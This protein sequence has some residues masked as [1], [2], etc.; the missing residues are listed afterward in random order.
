MAVYAHD[1]E[2]D[3]WD[4]ELSDDDESSLFSAL[5]KQV[6]ALPPL[7][8][9][10]AGPAPAHDEAPRGGDSAANAVVAPGTGSTQQHSAMA[11]NTSS[12]S[13][14][15]VASG[16]T[17]QRRLK[18]TKGDQISWK[19]RET[20]SHRVDFS[21]FFVRVGMGPGD[22]IEVKPSSRCDGDTGTYVA[23]GS[24]ELV[25]MF[26]NQFSW[27][28][29]KLVEFEVTRLKPEGSDSGSPSGA[30]EHAGL[31][32]SAKSIS[33][34]PST[35]AEEEARVE[36]RGAASEPQKTLPGGDKEDENALAASTEREESQA[37]RAKRLWEAEAEEARAR[38]R[39]QDGE[40]ED[41]ASNQGTEEDEVEASD[42]EEND[43]ADQETDRDED[44]AAANEDKK[45]S[46]VQIGEE[47]VRD[48]TWALGLIEKGKK[49]EAA[50]D[51]AAA[52]QL[53]QSAL[54]AL[55]AL[56]ESRPKLEARIERLQKQLG[57]APSVSST[58]RGDNAGFQ[59]AAQI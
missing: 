9:N 19:F 10:A 26:D 5:P 24:G 49:A 57:E 31:H 16:N 6:Q 51:Q 42:L 1:A 21:V 4:C 34:L 35:I 47:P 48:K 15:L 2:A 36:A 8:A 3:V 25:L 7:A 59:Y 46:E 52:V 11:S 30:G 32:A 56:G 22:E 38:W 17:K 43:D 18:L 20:S 28:T 33:T 37:G 12:L 58:E 44:S 53:F 27:W 40:T 14:I 45:G 50:D 13:E 54:E 23:K 39:E 41:D 29:D 55:D